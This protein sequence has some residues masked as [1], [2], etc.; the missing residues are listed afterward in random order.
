MSTDPAR[1]A[2]LTEM[3][4]PCPELPAGERAAKRHADRARQRALEELAADTELALLLPFPPTEE[5]A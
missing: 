1:D 2:W 5:T 3:W 4:L